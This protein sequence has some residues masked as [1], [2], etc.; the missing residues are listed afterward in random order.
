[1][2]R[3]PHL[4]RAFEDER[5]R[6]DVPDYFRNARIVEA[7]Y[8]EARALGV[9]PGPDPLAGIEADIALARALNVR[10]PA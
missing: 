8:R 4:V 10:K 2:I 1:M 5:A 9:F 6:G 3:N 7:L